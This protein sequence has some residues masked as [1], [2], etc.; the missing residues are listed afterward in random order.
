MF[1]YGSRL[2]QIQSL[3][4]GNTFDDVHQDNIAQLLFSQALSGS[5]THI[6]GADY[7]NF[8]IHFYFLP[9]LKNAFPRLKKRERLLTQ[10]IGLS[11]YFI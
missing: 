5:C 9:Y 6:S 8:L 2:A 1:F 4:L 7:G 11:T 10:I 3:A